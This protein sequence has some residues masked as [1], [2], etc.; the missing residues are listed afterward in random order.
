MSLL[1]ILLLK[2][3]FYTIKEVQ[4]IFLGNKRVKIF[5]FIFVLPLRM[6]YLSVIIKYV[7]QGF[8][9]MF[10]NVNLFQTIILSFKIYYKI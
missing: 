2:T 1:L 4:K 3:Q 8:S 9:S 10:R 5:T 6:S 7:P